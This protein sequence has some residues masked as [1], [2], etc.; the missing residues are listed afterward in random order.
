MLRR[1]TFAGCMAGIAALALFG[2]DSGQVEPGRIRSVSYTSGGGM[3]GGGVSSELR[4]NG[5][6]TA[7]LSTRE[8]AWHNTRETGM[9]Y[10]IGEEAFGIFASIANEYD[11]PRASRRRMSDLIAL[12]APTSS[13]S[14]VVEDDEGGYDVKASFS[15]GSEQELTAREREGFNAVAQALSELARESEGVPYAEPLELTVVSGGVQHHFVLNES[16]AAEEL[17]SRC[18]LE[19]VVES[20]GEG[21]RV[22]RLDEPIDVSEATPATGKA[23]TLCYSEPQGCI[24]ILTDDAGPHE[25]LFELGRVQEEYETQFLSD[26]EP[27]ECGVWSNASA[28]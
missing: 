4:R 17:A 20:Q 1:R 23:G 22:L 28:W 8:R 19:A 24:V 27:G 11:L 21:E 26:I 5:D 16:A 18:P 7:T 15:I 12:D 2:C 9:D 25:G 3:T 13:V 6:G 14:Y 10:V